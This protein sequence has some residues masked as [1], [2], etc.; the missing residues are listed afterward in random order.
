MKMTPQLWEE[1][2]EFTT[3]H[4]RSHILQ[5]AEWG[6][7]KSAW[8]NEFVIVRNEEGKI[9]GTLSILIRKIPMFPCT[10][11]YAPRGQSVIF[12]MRKC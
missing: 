10:F 9:S 7:V 6:Q 11:M 5:S 2:T 3:K 8:T 12:M 1:Y 4:P